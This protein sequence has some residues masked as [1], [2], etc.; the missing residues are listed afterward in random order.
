MGAVP[1][2]PYY[3]LPCCLPARDSEWRDF[4][5]RV[6][7]EVVMELGTIKQ[8]HPATWAHVQA[9]IREAMAQG[10]RELAVFLV[11]MWRDLDV[12]FWYKHRRRRSPAIG[13]SAVFCKAKG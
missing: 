13:S 8:A 7:I 2:A 1:R 12:H 10:D 4:T 11:V 6:K 5:R 9:M 3:G